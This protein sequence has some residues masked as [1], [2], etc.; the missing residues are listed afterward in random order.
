M[1]ETDTCDLMRPCPLLFPSFT[2][3]GE[4]AIRYGQIARAVKSDTYLPPGYRRASQRPPFTGIVRDT[5]RYA[6][7][8]PG[9]VERLRRE[10][11]K[12]MEKAEIEKFSHCRIRRTRRTTSETV[13]YPTAAAAAALNSRSVGTLWRQIREGFSIYCTYIFEVIEDE[14]A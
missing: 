9:D 7:E 5:G 12:E 6:H 13:E 14:T 2:V 3:T 8:S 1:A 10:R 11:E 4:A